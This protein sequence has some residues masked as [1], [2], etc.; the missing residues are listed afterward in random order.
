MVFFVCFFA[1]IS[2]LGTTVAKDRR[3]MYRFTLAGWSFAS[4]SVLG[5]TVAKDWRPM[6]AD[7][8][9][10]SISDLGPTAPGL[11]AGNVSI[12]LCGQASLLSVSF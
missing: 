4:I 1:S 8:S 2:D 6:L 9:F 10:A 12:D 11:P 7:R 5:R 3:P